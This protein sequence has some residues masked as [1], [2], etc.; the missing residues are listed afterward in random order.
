M[1]SELSQYE[2]AFDDVLAIIQHGQQKAYRAA[3]SAMLETYWNI[4]CYLSR[5]IHHGQWG[6][7]VVA[8]LSRWLQFRV[9]GIRG[10]SPQNLWRMKQIV[11]LYSEDEKLSPLVREVGWTQNCIIMAQCKQSEEREFYLKST[12]KAG[13]TKTELEQQ[14]SSGAFE[15]TVLSDKKLSPTVRELPQDVFGI[16][17]DSYS[18]EFLGLPEQHLEK[19]LQSALVENLRKFL[20][21]LGDGFTYIGEK[22]RVQVGNK[23]F[24]LDLL[25]FHR[26]LQ[27][28]VAFELKTGDFEP[29]HLGQLSFYLEALDRQKKRPHENPTIG[30]LLCK[31]KDDEVVEVA[32]SRTLAPALVSDY[33]TK[34]IPK[35]LLKRKLHEWSEMLERED[36]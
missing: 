29:S 4:G 17:K 20:L 15:R 9:P 19:D 32:L 10:F 11:E 25:F 23:D 35:E 27:C 8:E 14:I 1:S 33:Q 5:Q 28:M 26:D 2:N 6:K 13:W 36:V 30:V 18:L 22:V 12:I 24:E 16:F 21:E 7:S 31:S 34:M 3:N